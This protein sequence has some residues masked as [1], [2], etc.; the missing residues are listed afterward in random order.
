VELPVVKINVLTGGY[1]SCA[2]HMN[3]RATVQPGLGGQDVKIKVTQSVT[4][5]IRVWANRD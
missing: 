4:G 3:L 2:Q 1:V 5:R